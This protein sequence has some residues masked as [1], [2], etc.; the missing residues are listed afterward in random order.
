VEIFRFPAEFFL[1]DVAVFPRILEYVNQ[2]NPVFYH[3]VC[4]VVFGIGCENLETRQAFPYHGFI[5]DCT[6]D[7]CKMDLLFIAWQNDFATMEYRASVG[8][9]L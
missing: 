3:S 6:A 2:G 1:P 5:A 7:V 9:H 8:R 4:L